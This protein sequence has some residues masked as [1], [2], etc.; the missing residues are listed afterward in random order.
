M[1][2]FSAF[3]LP[4]LLPSLHSPEEQPGNLTQSNA[5][6]F[7]ASNN[8][9]AVADTSDELAMFKQRLDT[10]RSRLVGIQQML[11][12]RDQIVGVAEMMY[13]NEDILQCSEIYVQFEDE[14]GEDFKG[15]TRDFFSSYWREVTKNCTAGETQ[16][17]FKLSPST[18][19]NITSA[20]ATGRIL[21]HGYLV[22]G[23]LPH[24]INHATLYYILAHKDPST[25]IV[26]KAFKECLDESTQKC[27]EDMENVSTLTS[28]LTHRLIM[29]FS[30]H[31]THVVPSTSRF[32]IQDSRFF[33]FQIST[34]W[35]PSIS[36][37]YVQ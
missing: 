4:L 21:L 17:Y 5:I 32:K 34:I 30:Q 20:Q 15:V 6:I 36:R 35:G 10:I 23:Y 12:N 9:T 19:I 24:F 25:E 3:T 7:S 37:S 13:G 18:V 29:F 2:P 31:D 14:E 28:D 8:E 33:S 26:T 1:S 16:R 27:I 11:V 22:C